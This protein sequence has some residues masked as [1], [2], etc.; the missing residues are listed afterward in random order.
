MPEFRLDHAVTVWKGK[1]KKIQDLNYGAFKPGDDSEQN[2]AYI[3]DAGNEDAGYF[4]D[5]SG[6][7]VFRY[8][9]RMIMRWTELVA[10]A[11]LNT[12]AVQINSEMMDNEWLG[13]AEGYWLIDS[14]NVPISQQ[15]V[16]RRYVEFYC[17][18]EGNPIEL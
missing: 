15:L 4:D 5:D 7:R 18:R 12:I 1:T 10:R 9:L 2:Y 16:R 17:Y 11:R 3:E 8:N 14:R 6:L 13:S